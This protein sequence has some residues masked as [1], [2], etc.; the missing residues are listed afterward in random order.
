MLF[1]S[2]SSSC[3]K[4]SHSVQHNSSK[5]TTVYERSRRINWFTYRTTLKPVNLE[6][7]VKKNS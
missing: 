5:L 1:S 6:L 2:S 7:K 3:V 4:T